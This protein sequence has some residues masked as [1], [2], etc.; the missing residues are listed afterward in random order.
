MQ[1]KLRRFGN[2]ADQQQQTDRRDDHAALGQLMDAAEDRC[3]IH[4]PEVE[5]DQEG[6]EDHAHVADRVHHEGLARRQHRRRTLE[7]EANQQV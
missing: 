4:H 6:G 7:P 5:K 1:R 2:R 3:V